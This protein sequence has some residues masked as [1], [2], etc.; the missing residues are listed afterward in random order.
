MNKLLKQSQKFVKRNA[1]TILTYAGGAGVIA[2][3]VLAVKAT[4]KAMELLEDAKKEKGGELTKTEAVVTAAP[5]YIPT[6]IT[7]VTTLACIFGANVLNKRQQAALMSAY[8]LLD[9]SY[10]DYKAKVVELHGEEGANQVRDE[11]AKDRYDEQR[12]PVAPDKQLFYDEFLGEY[13]ESTIEDV[14][15]AEYHVNRELQLSGGVAICEFYNKLGIDYDD[16]SSLGWS[17]GGNYAKYW[18]DW[19]DFTHTKTTVDNDTLECTIIT[20]WQ[21]PYMDYEENW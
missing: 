4:P 7:G 21:E 17:V 15:K 14:I 12:I 20:M 19:I 10:K 11:I 13:F 8:A 16:G 6:I 18:Q 3:T 1:A 5:A 9:K 2:T